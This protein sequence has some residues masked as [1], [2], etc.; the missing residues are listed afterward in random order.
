MQDL[1]STENTL[2]NDFLQ[3]EQVINGNSPEF[4]RKI[5]RKAIESFSRLGLPGP[6]NELWR[7]SDIRKVL[8]NM[9]R[10][11]PALV[12]PEDVNTPVNEIFKCDI[13]ELDS[14]DLETINGWFP[15]SLPLIQHFNGKG[16]AGSLAAAFQLYPEIIEKYYGKAA[17]FEDPFVDLNIAY[18]TDGIFAVFPE[19]SKISKPL[20][21]VSL[22]TQ[23]EGI[24]THPIVHPH[25]LIIVGKNSRI[26][27]VLCDHTL[28]NQHSFTDVVTEIF[29]E[30]NAVVKIIRLQNQSNKSAMVSS[31]FIR[32]A[33]GSYVTTNT[34]T[35]NGGYTR[36][37]QNLWLEGKEAKA[38]IFGLYLMDRKQHIDN[39]TYIEHCTAD[40]VSNE[41]FKGILDDQSSGVF[42]GKIHVRKNAQH[43]NSYQK[44]SSLLLTDDARINTMPQL[45]IYA[46]DVKCSHGATVGYLS[47]DELFYLRSRGI[48]EYEARIMLMKSFTSEIIDKIEIPALQERISFLVSKR[49]RGELSHCATCVLNCYD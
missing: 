49:L 18:A 20:Q 46:D 48:C 43:T 8:E 23:K 17:H 38:D 31:L 21:L 12:P 10:L 44:N 9:G 24:L 1:L 34:I 47:S 29:V 36:N 45:E 25:N 5:R 37:N 6:N 28:T 15:H 32:Q 30:E 14:F 40:T 11:L 39:T 27:L 22:V 3:N 7:F 41:L 19:N 42:R 16:I 4:I 35:L 2:I 26:S 13:N 33:A